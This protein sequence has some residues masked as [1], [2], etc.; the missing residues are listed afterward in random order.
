MPASHCASAASEPAS[1]TSDIA[2]GEL[3]SNELASG[4]PASNELASVELASGEPASGE[5]AST[6]G[7]TSSTIVIGE[8][9]VPLQAVRSRR[10][11]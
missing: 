9:G 7:S 8:S 5:L 4:E 6:V 11:L 3:A 1:I 10:R 2:S